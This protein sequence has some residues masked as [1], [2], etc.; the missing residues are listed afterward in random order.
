MAAGNGSPPRWGSVTREGNMK[1]VYIKWMVSVAMFFCLGCLVAYGGEITVDYPKEPTITKTVRWSLVGGAD[2]YRFLA[3]GHGEDD[4]A[5]AEAAGS[6]EQASA[7]V[8]ESGTYTL[9]ARK[10]ENI[11]FVQI[12]ITTIDHTPPTIRITDILS[13]SE[14]HISVYYEIDDYYGVNEVRY[15]NGKVPES[16]F[17][18]A[19]IATGGVIEGLTEG[20]YTLFAK[21]LA[22][23]ITTYS[24]AVT[25]DYTESQWSTEYESHHEVHE[26]TEWAK[27]DLW[28]EPSSEPVTMEKHETPA[29]E[30]TQEETGTHVPASSEHIPTNPVMPA[31][32]PPIERY[33]QT[34]STMAQR[35]LRAGI[36]F[37]L[38]MVG[39]TFL[40]LGRKR[41]GKGEDE[42]ETGNNPS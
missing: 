23:N 29:P 2:E 14:K 15:K 40:L 27:S 5:Q 28:V 4:F 11:Y 41:G 20:T 3:G 36:I 13:T 16:D 30:P 1:L 32:T 24:M 12:P 25:N 33:P 9:Y 19:A 18:S 35:L 26:S 10:E 6:G 37:L 39:M 8:D 22:G 17:P 38:F 34:G 7:M 42:E 21:D 31:Q